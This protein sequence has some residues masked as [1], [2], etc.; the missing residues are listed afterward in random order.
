MTILERVLKLLEERHITDIALCDYIGIKSGQFSTWKKRNTDPPA[1]YISKIA[2]FFE[3]GERY[4]LT[5]E[6]DK[7]Y[8]TGQEWRLINAFRD[9]S[10]YSKEIYFHTVEVAAKDPFLNNKK[11]DTASDK[12]G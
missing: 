10:T 3:V 9:L 4:I 5:G 8:L 2:D 7:Y 1:K 6:K 11:P 12:V